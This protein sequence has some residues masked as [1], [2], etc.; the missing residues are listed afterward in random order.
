MVLYLNIVLRIPIVL[1]GVILG[2][3][4]LVSP[5]LGSLVSVLTKTFGKLNTLILSLLLYGVDTSLLVWSRDLWQPTMKSVY[6]RHASKL[7]NPDNAFR[8]NYLSICLGAILGSAVVILL[9]GFRPMASLYIT[10]ALYITLIVPVIV[11]RRLFDEGNVH[12][13]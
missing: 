2:I 9:G 10:A 3:P 1:V 4:S 7:D 12:D 5:L 6:A 11:C 13:Q 8:L